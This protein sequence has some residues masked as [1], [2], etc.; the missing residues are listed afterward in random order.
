MNKKQYKWLSLHGVSRRFESPLDLKQQLLES[1]GDHV[2]ALSSIDT[3]NVGYLQRKSQTKHWIVSDKDIDSM[4]AQYTEDI[5][6]WC[7]QRVEEVVTSSNAAKQKRAGAENAPPPK[8]T[9]Y[10]DREEAIEE[11]ATEL[12][13]F[14]GDNYSYPQYK[15]WA[16]LIACGQHTDKE[17]PP[18]VPMIT[19]SYSKE[20]K[21]K[22]GSSDLGEIIA[23]AAVAI[24]KAL[25]DPSEKNASVTSTVSPGKRASLSGQYLKQLEIIQKLKDEGVLSLNEYQAQKQRIMENL[26]PL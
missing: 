4:Y 22:A 3:F 12:N 6:L 9:N 23:G 13:E 8:R 17:N 19:G 25:K 14:H 5:S 18:N 2:P 7:D 15:L 21:Q 1:L 24:V 26:Q 16:R 10:T 20:R 11:I